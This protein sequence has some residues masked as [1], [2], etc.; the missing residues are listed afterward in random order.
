MFRF[1]ITH[2][3]VAAV[4]GMPRFNSGVM[5]LMPSKR[6]FVKLKAFYRNRNN[7]YLKN[8]TFQGR[9]HDQQLLGHF[10]KNNALPRKYNC[11]QGHR[12]TNCL[13]LHN[14]GRI[15]NNNAIP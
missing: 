14:N 12:D 6:V 13:I 10:F 3:S 11:I 15:K 8:E 5:V 9:P 1:N 7:W 2:D 4:I